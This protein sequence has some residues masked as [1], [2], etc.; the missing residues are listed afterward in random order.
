MIYQSSRWTVCP[1]RL[2]RVVQTQRNS[3][4]HA[5]DISSTGSLGRTMGVPVHAFRLNSDA[6]YAVLLFT[7]FSAP[8]SIG[9]ARA[10]GFGMY[11]FITAGPIQVK[12]CSDRGRL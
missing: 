5:N 10:G 12:S 6:G 4:F 2:Y 7:L 3:L 9:E 1:L 8:V 11:V